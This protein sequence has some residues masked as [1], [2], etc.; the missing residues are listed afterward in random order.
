MNIRFSLVIFIILTLALA[1]FSNAGAAEQKQIVQIAQWGA[2]FGTSSYILA[3]A[4]SDIS[5]KYHPWLRVSAAETPGNIYILKAIDKNPSLWTNTVATSG[6]V[7]EWLAAKSLPP[8][9]EEIVGFRALLNLNVLSMW[10]VTFDPGIKTPQDLIGKKIALG[11][12][13]QINWGY[14][15]GLLINE[16]WG[17]K[18]KVSITYA[19]T[20]PALHA[21]LDRTAHATVIGVYMNPITYDYVP[22]P[23]LVELT[24]SGKKFYH[25]PW[26][27]ECIEAAKAKLG[28]P[29]GTITI[30]KGTIKDQTEDIVTFV[31]TLHLS[32]RDLFPEEVAYEFVKMYIAHYKKFSDY[33]VVGKLITPEAMC[34]GFTKRELHPGAV[35]AYKEAGFTIPEK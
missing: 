25:I 13:T 26:G 20:T 34:Y 29:L 1:V 21:L 28:I 4:T 17:L 16:G 18:D 10:L 22:A 2:T 5:K 15:P 35:R 31:D 33:H 7:T 14:E 3:T 19:G 12:T 9:T 8:F 27:K 32:V 11:L 24:A 30:P 23:S 6:K